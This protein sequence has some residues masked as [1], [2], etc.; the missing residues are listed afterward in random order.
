MG[1]KVFLGEH[2]RC[3]KQSSSQ[4]QPTRVILLQRMPK[5]CNT[6]SDSSIFCSEEE[7][8]LQKETGDGLLVENSSRDASLLCHLMHLLSSKC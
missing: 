8:T 4:K 1:M 6:V 3:D 7:H 2:Y 5:F